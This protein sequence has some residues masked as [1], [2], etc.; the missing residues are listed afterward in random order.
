MGT[1]NGGGRHTLSRDAADQ[2]IENGL[3]YL[4]EQRAFGVKRARL[5]KITGGLKEAGR[6]DL[7][8]LRNRVITVRGELREAEEQC[9]HAEEINAQEAEILDELLQLDAEEERSAL[10]GESRISI[11]GVEGG[12]MYAR[13][14]F[15]TSRFSAPG[16]SSSARS[17][18][19]C[20]HPKRRR[21]K[22]QRAWPEEGRDSDLRGEHGDRAAPVCRSTS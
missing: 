20:R 9:A 7:E 19:A 11:A 21:S 2:A 12:F 8:R 3:F 22:V 14:R 4:E 13:K 16:S 18:W 1:S 15:L 10:E 6:I 17:A 5:L